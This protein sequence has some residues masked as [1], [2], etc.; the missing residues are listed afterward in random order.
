M[1]SGDRFD[2]QKPFQERY[3]DILEDRT[4]LNKVG[5]CRRHTL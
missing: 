1:L 5:V 3:K 2:F 4:Y